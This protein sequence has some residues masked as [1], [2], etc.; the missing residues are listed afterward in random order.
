MTESRTTCT[1]ELWDREV[2][3]TAD[4]MCPLCLVAELTT[5]R[6]DLAAAQATQKKK[7]R[8]AATLPSDPPMDCDAPFCGC[9]PAWIEALELANESGWLNETQARAIAAELEKV[10]KDAERYR[11]L[12]QKD[13][14][15]IAI[16]DKN[17]RLKCGTHLDR[18]IDAAIDAAIARGGKP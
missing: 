4:G 15:M 18:W 8:C 6:G 11:W 13:N 16:D 7:R 17:I 5:V 1:H 10:R 12:N 2:A 3:V 14:F 9:N